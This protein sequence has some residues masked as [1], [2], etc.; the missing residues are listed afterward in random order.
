MIYLDHAATTPCRPEAMEAMLPYLGDTFG[1]PSSVHLAGQEA[2]KA[3]EDA[4]QRV[5]EVLGVRPEEVVFTGGG[6]EGDNA[7]IFGSYHYWRGRKNHVISAGTEHDAVLNSVELLRAWGVEVTLLP[8]DSFGRVDPADLKAAIRRDTFLVSLM[9]ANNEV[10]T[11]HP[12]A[13]LGRVCREAEVP[14]HTDAVQWIG[15]LPA[16]TDA[17]GV[18]FLVCTAHKFYG[19]KGTGVLVMRRGSRLKPFLVGGGQERGHRAGTVNVAGAVGFAKAIELAAEEQETVSQRL[20]SLRQ[21]LWSGI[22]DRLGGA[23]LNG[24]PTERL[25]NNLNVSFPGVESDVLVLSLDLEGVACSSG[26][27]CSAGAIE[28][29]HVLKAMNLPQERQTSALR[30]TLGRGTTTEEIDSTLAAL[31]RVVQ[32]IRGHSPTQWA[33]A[34]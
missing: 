1:N 15:A 28:P 25:P 6:T 22:Q 14:F 32:R 7:V 16:A 24:H 12:M 31:E 3:L 34:G 9:A 18:N 26:S 27:A 11:L 19:P 8:V 2:R 5:A 30:L 21:R 17:W 29:S 23:F 4:R 20:E 10:G 13:E 33:A